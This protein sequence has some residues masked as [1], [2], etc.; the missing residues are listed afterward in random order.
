MTEALT[1]ALTAAADALD[2]QKDELTRLDALQGDGDLGRTAG[3][4]A[5]T[6]RQVVGEAPEADAPALLLG[7]GTRIAFAAPSSSGTLIASAFIGA[8]KAIQANTSRNPLTHG[9]HA[10]VDAV[11]QRGKAKPGDR[12]MLDAAVPALNQL[13]SDPSDLGGAARAAEAGA[14]ATRGM[15]ARIGRARFL[16]GNAKGEPD[17]GAVMIA[18]ALSAA[19][20]AIVDLAD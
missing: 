8:A 1:A 14:E 2:E 12:T 10:A 17:P 16:A 18:V 4:I 20:R 13:E 11:Q 9:L 3:T 15:E 7:V 19:L 6:I 5:S